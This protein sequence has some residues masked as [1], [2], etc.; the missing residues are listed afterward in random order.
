M[1]NPKYQKTLRS[2]TERGLELKVATFLWEQEKMG[3]D[4][5]VGDYEYCPARIPFWNPW[6]VIMTRV[7]Y[8]TV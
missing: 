6:I 2:A 3:V 7:E 8:E 1:Y 4:W 5:I